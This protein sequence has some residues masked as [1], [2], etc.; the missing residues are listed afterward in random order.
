M[1]FLNKIKIFKTNR[2]SIW[3]L[4]WNTLG[5]FLIS[6]GADGCVFIW[7][8]TSSEI[9][10]DSKIRSLIEKKIYSNWNCI[11][12][13]MKGPNKTTHR[14]L[15]ISK[16]VYQIGISTF[17]GDTKICKIFFPKNIRKIFLT[18]LEVLNGPT[19]EI[20][21]C[22]FSPD[23][24]NLIACSRNKMVW[25]WEKDS[26]N[27]F[28][29]FFVLENH[30]SD[31]KQ[32]I[33]HPQFGIILTSTYE[34]NVRLF[35]KNLE[36][37]W[38]ISSLRFSFFSIFTI[39]TDESGEKII[40]SSTK[41]E[42]FIFP[43]WKNF[44]NKSF[45]FSKKNSAFF[46]F[47]IGNHSIFKF[48]ISKSNFFFSLSGKDD[49]LHILKICSIWVWDKIFKIFYIGIRYFEILSFENSVIRSHC[50]N[51]NNLAWH[52][53]NENLVA[54]CSEDSCIILWNFSE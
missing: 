6:C 41:G 9:S 29:S 23:G 35:Q 7:G 37:I 22:S 30:E 11:T 4:K 12:F 36:E 49:S 2:A 28:N 45:Y 18:K 52:P 1:F 50:G 54:S 40:F 20:K 10:F 17:T 51:L 34:G 42:L 26:K 5:T 8:L 15:S 31:I 47:S 24:S 32:S 27:F 16:N 53:K 46:F 14:T 25:N 38:I 33:W 48:D 44:F 39:T 21:N 43:F 19:S 13:Q 3:S